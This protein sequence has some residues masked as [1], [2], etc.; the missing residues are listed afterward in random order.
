MAALEQ[1]KT[2]L[3]APLGIAKRGQ[4]RLRQA[5]QGHVLRQLTLQKCHGIKARHPNH[6]Q[7]RQLADAGSAGNVRC[8]TGWGHGVF[9]SNG[10][11][12]ELS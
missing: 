5:E 6:P 2:G 7:M 8:W 3:H 12:A 10:R 11:R 1:H 4:T 9:H